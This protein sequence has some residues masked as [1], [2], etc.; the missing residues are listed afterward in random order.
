MDSIVGKVMRPFAAVWRVIALTLVICATGGA[1]AATPTAEWCGT[2]PVDPYENSSGVQSSKNGTC[3]ISKNNYHN[4]STAKGIKILSTESGWPITVQPDSAMAGLTVVVGY[5]NPTSSSTGTIVGF[6]SNQASNGTKINANICSGGAIELGWGTEYNW[7]ATHNGNTLN[8]TQPD[9]GDIHYVTLAYA[10]NATEGTT[11]WFDGANKKNITS[12]GSSGY[13]SVAE[14]TL[15]AIRGPYN[16]LKGV[17]FVYVAVYSGVLSDA[18]AATAYS[19]A[20]SKVDALV[21]YEK[22]LYAPNNILTCNSAFSNFESPNYTLF[23]IDSGS[24]T[25]TTYTTTVSPVKWQCFAYSNASGFDST[26]YSE[27]GNVLR[28]VN[29]GKALVAKFAPLTIGGMIVESTATGCSFE[30]SGGGTNRNTLF[31]DPTAANETWFSFDTSF[32]NARKGTAG[33]IG[34]VNFEVAAGASVTL[35]TDATVYISGASSKAAG[36]LPTQTNG[37]VLKMHGEGS[38]TASCINANG[39]TLDFSDIGSRYNDTTPFINGELVVNTDTKF[40]FPDGISFPYT[41]KVAA[42]ISDG[43]TIPS[44]W[45]VDGNVYTGV[46]SADKANGTITIAS[47]LSATAIEVNSDL[48]ISGATTANITVNAGKTLTLE[49]G[50]SLSGTVTGS[51]TIV[52]NQVDLSGSGFDNASGWTGTV[53]IAGDAYVPAT[54]FDEASYGNANST[55]EIVS[56]HVCITA[57]TTLPGSVT[58]ASG[59]TLYMTSGSITSLSIIGT[60]SGTIHLGSAGAL[61]TLSL[62]DGVARGT[63]VYPASLTT[64]NVALTELI[65]DDGRA[66]FTCT[67]ATLTGGTLTLTKPDGTTESVTG[68]VDGATVSFAWTPSVSGAACWCDY[69]MDYVS[70]NASKTGFENSGT[71]TTGLHS[72]S[73]IEGSDAFTTDGMLY[74]YAHPWR[75]ITYPTDGNW[76]AVVR[77][78]VPNYTDAAVITFGT[79]GGGLIGLLAGADPETQMVL[80]KT[81]GNSAY[82]PLVTNTVQNATTAQHVYV[83]SV[84]TNQTVKI[85]CDG[86]KVLD[87]EFDAPFSIGGGIQIGSVHGGVG[88]TKIVRFAKDESPANTL[89]ETV[90]K[91]TR[92][93]CV[94]LY[95]TVLGPNAIRQHSV[96]F[97]AVKLYRATVADGATTD[98]DSLSWSPAWDGGNEYSK[99]IL[100]SEGDASL[101]LPSTIT[102][103]DFSIEVAAGKV[104]TLG[105]A[106]GGTTLTLTHPIE[107]N[108]GS[109]AFEETE[110]EMDFIVGGTGSIFVDSGKTISVVSGGSISKLV[111]SGTVTYEDY[112]SLPGALTFG[113]WTGTVVLPSFAANGQ[114]LNNYGKSGSTLVLNGI[115]GGWLN[116]T[117]SGAVSV[118]PALRLDGNVTITGFSTSWSYTFAEITGTGDLSFAPTDNHP[119][120]LAITKVAAGFSGAITNLTDKT[121]SIGTLDRAAETPVTAGSKLLDTS[122]GI[123]ASALTLAGVATDIIPVFDTDG[124]YVKAASVT[125]NDSTTNYNLLSDAVTALGNDAGILTLLMSTDSNFALAPGQTLKNANLTS[126]S[127]TSSVNGYEIRQTGSTYELVDNRTSTWT[128]GGTAGSWTDGA[129]WSTGFK[130]TQYTAV[131]FPAGDGEEPASYTISLTASNGSEACKS[132]A[133][134]GNLTLQYSGGSWVEFYMFG[135]VSG[136]GTLTLSHVCLN[137]RTNGQI[138]I[139]CPVAIVGSSDSALLGTGTWLITGDLAVNGYF[140]AQGTSVT[141]S[142][143]VTFAASGATVE[144]QAN[145]TII[146]S[147]TLNGGFSRDTSYGTDRLTFG[148]VTVAAPATITGSRPTTFSGTVTLNVGASLTVDNGFTFASTPVASSSY[149]TVK[150]ETGDST[151]VYSVEKKPGTIFSVY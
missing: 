77:C 92:I 106:D 107:V 47:L 85:Y 58:V 140:K 2:F 70:G 134:E 38:V 145:I 12:L 7:S 54:Y 62:S 89:S 124:L 81:T 79:Q 138:E 56:G 103:E 137:N 151:T 9:D 105:K 14:I 117:S 141:V 91:A 22:W 69:E 30:A 36:T 84:E 78:T 127:I 94:R 111:G 128:G 61:A 24:D 95:K 129:N 55:L 67:G 49:S 65:A 40:V 120:S 4:V 8:V 121:L 122:S 119:G 11:F 6:S 23:D 86:E 3:T 75:N 146:G 20:K 76:T 136:T 10:G 113:T 97:P 64:L 99:I 44:T 29:S 130:P 27:P 80:V 73:Y 19:S 88:N 147:T 114:N 17:E 35:A 48:T 101:T 93:D 51:G 109:I 1:W 63:I 33:I 144:T 100:T 39:A 25:E 131:T 15:G 21:K 13:T 135:G 149:Y 102:A 72:D 42:S 139:S 82:T 5:R 123:V 125:K 108:T 66:S 34:T 74:T 37:G 46:V 45:T 96:E 18:D 110:M 43:S 116:E 115:T 59:S 126:G 133:L 53:Q 28:L 50:A 150:T 60:N 26:A 31:G 83:F 71:D 118:A 90:Q 143:D 104:L 16:M 132:I 41:Y 148:D 112:G 142:G 87:K 52:C 68:T 98:W 32:T 57:A